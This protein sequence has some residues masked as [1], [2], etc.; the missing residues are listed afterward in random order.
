MPGYLGHV[1]DDVAH[2]PGISSDDDAVD[3]LDIQ[4]LVDGHF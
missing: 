1:L 2:V 4:Q 3:L